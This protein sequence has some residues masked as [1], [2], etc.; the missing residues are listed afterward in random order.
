MR[1][2]V[3]MVCVC[4]EEGEVEVLGTYAEKGTLA[5]VRVGESG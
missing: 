5:W 4:A 2:W 1:E 3:V